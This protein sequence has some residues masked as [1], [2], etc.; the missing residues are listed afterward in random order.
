[1]PICRCRCSVLWPLMPSPCV[2]STYNAF[3]Y[4][5]KSHV[6]VACSQQARE[7]YQTRGVVFKDDAMYPYR[8]RGHNVGWD[9]VDKD[10]CMR[11]HAQH[12]EHGPIRRSIWF[13][14]AKLS[15]Y[16]QRIKAPEEVLLGQHGT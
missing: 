1:M 16:R 15:R 7:R 5:L 4:V 10:T 6:V 12:R 9:I 2:V 13:H 14:D 3:V 8:L 11:G